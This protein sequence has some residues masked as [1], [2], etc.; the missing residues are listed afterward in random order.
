MAS[1]SKTPHGLN[2]WA[3]TDKPTR[4]DFNDDN[5]T[6]EQNALWKAEYDPS[7]SGGAGAVETAGGIPAYVAANAMTSA[8]YDPNGSIASNGGIEAVVNS[9]TAAALPKTGGAI[10]GNLSVSGTL[11]A[12]GNIT[13]QNTDRSVRGVRNTE[14]HDASGIVS[15]NWLKFVR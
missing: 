6:L 10:T 4:A 13:A 12:G 7:V 5:M 8:V 9:A 14:V 1:L 15:T 2:D 11:T 3:G